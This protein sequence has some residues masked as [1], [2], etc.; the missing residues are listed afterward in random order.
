VHAE[1]NSLVNQM[2]R[3]IGGDMR[4]YWSPS[5]AFF[6]ALPTA[7]LRRLALTLLPKERQRGLLAAR[8]KHLVQALMSA[9]EDAAANLPTMDKASIERLNAWVPEELGFAAPDAKAEDVE[10]DFL[11]SFASEDAE[12]A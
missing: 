6:E 1:A 9:F 5:H 7:E 2:G 11:A 12:A 10:D 8:K 4:R 3:A